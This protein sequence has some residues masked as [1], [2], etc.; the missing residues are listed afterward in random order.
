MVPMLV[1]VSAVG[2]PKCVRSGF[3]KDEYVGRIGLS[4]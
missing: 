3:S 2:G 4:Y 1:T